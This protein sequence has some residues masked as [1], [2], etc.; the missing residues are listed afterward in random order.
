MTIDLQALEESLCKSL[1]REVRIVRGPDK[2]LMLHTQFAFPDGD[3]YPIHLRELDD[4][5][6]RLSDK[7]H[8]LMHISYAHDVDALLKGSRG[9]LLEQIMKEMSIQWEE[10]TN[11]FSVD[12]AID[13][14]SDALF[15]MAQGLTRIYDLPLHSRVGSA[16]SFYED[17]KRII[18]SLVDKKRIKKD[19]LAE[20]P[21]AENYTVD[22]RIKGANT[23][24][25]LYGIANTDAAR[26]VNVK[27][28]YFHRYDLNFN[29]LLVF[30]DQTDIPRK[31][32]ARLSDVGGE[33]VSSLGSRKELES[34]LEHRLAA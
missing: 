21:N 32:L 34:K 3:R 5:R 31:D 9:A 19:Y 16:S 24:L 10:G 7:G 13:G 14:L 30:R 27:L 1:C 4:G 29:S 26:L 22:Y 20:V 2:D 28:F 8:T 15:R 23:P 18:F 11:A 17:L 33:M 6:L 12:T 25:F